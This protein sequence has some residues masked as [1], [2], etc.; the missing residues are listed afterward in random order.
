MK[1]C[2]NCRSIVDDF[3]SKCPYCLTEIDFVGRSVERVR[4][5]DELLRTASPAEKSNALVWAICIGL[6]V[7][8]ILNAAGFK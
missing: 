8:W 1:T 4:R 3:A 7:A 6:V 5:T 2:E